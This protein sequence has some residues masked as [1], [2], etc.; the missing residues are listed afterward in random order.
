[1]LKK[2][3]KYTGIDGVERNEEFFFNLNK[4]EIVKLLT[5]TDGDYTLD[6][7]LENLMRRKNGKEIMD[8]FHMIIMTSYGVPTPD[9]KKFDKSEAVKNEFEN[10]E[11]YSELFMEL[12]SDAEAAVK[13]MKEVIPKSITD[14]VEKIV[15]ANPNGIPAEMKDYLLD[16]K[17]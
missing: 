6:K 10:S 16:K 17:K 5:S 15:A 2:M 4:A 8:F 13:F 14:E 9:G 3:I 1:M 11:A 7:Y 12:V